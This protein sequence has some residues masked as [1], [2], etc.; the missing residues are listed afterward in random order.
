[1]K[2]GLQG[3]VVALGLA[4]L[5]PSQVLAGYEITQSQTGMH[6]AATSTI[7]ISKNKYAI[8]QPESRMSINFATQRIMITN[9]DQ[10]TFWE[11]T[12]DEYLRTVQEVQ[13]ASMARMKEMLQK[14]PESQ[15][16]EI[17]AIHGIDTAK[18]VI[19]VTVKRTGK[20]EMIAGYR[21]EH[22]IVD[23]NGQPFEEL[24]LAKGLNIGTEISPE[25]LQAF[26]AKLKKATMGGSTEGGI[27][28]SRAYLNLTKQG[29][30]LKQVIER[31]MMTVSANS[32]KKSAVP[33]AEF[34]V[35]AGYARVKSLKT[36]LASRANSMNMKMQ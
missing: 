16:K 7:Y 26:L 33:D 11:G 23:N 4:L 3:M 25:R 21:T 6:G 30:P 9:E 2:Q 10:K 20:T 36:F 32:V 18:P 22:Y 24:W 27:G 13:D 12:E 34:S 14:L 31:T 29:Y 19:H 17:M 15:R 5:L 8:V 35:P 28:L 1:M